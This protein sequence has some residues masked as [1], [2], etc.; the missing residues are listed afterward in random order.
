MT[1][2]KKENPNIKQ[3]KKKSNSNEFQAKSLII[4]HNTSLKNHVRSRLSET[5]TE[6]TPQPGNCDIRYICN[7]SIF[8]NIITGKKKTRIIEK[9]GGCR[10]YALQIF[11]CKL[12][13]NDHKFLVSRDPE[14]L[15]L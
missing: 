10:G 11:G 12:R 8:T 1:L 14:S 3:K 6:K 2:I 15:I 7:S 9:K 4:T 5:Q 13:P